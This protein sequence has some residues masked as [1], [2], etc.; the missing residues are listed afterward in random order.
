MV[1]RVSDMHVCYVICMYMYAVSVRACT[2][3]SASPQEF[4]RYGKEITIC[5]L[6]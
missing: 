5:D 2:V 3:L 6:R 1:D 4:N